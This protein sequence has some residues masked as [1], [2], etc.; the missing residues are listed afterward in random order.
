MMLFQTITIKNCIF[1]PTNRVE[2][3]ISGVMAFNA[4]SKNTYFFYNLN[5]YNIF[6]G[7]FIKYVVVYNPIR[8]R[9]IAISSVISNLNIQGMVVDLLWNF[10][11]ITLVS[12]I[13]ETANFTS[14]SITDGAKC[15][16]GSQCIDIRNGYIYTG[17]F[18]E[19]NCLKVFINNLNYLNS[20]SR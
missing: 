20:I 8:A 17:G 4:L 13:L 15:G 3:S 19:L 1:L 18:L 6:T 11:D 7:N 9:L 10:E 14:I 5:F 12:G 16:R 2:H